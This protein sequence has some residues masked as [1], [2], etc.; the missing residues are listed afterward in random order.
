MIFCQHRRAQVPPCDAHANIPAAKTSHRTE[1]SFRGVGSSPPLAAGLEGA[2][3]F[4]AEWSQPL[5]SA[6]W[7]LTPPH[8]VAGVPGSGTLWLISLP[9]LGRSGHLAARCR[10]QIGGL[11][12]LEETS[13]RPPVFSL[14]PCPPWCLSP[15]PR[16]P[17]EF[18]KASWSASLLSPTPGLPCHQTDT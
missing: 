6:V 1:A 4:Y 5:Q 17:L 8:T 2:S 12:V 7:G 3:I 13:N 15:L 9:G 16:S 18:C 11:T 14:L 10:R